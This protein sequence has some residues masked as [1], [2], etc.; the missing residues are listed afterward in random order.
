[1]ISNTITVIRTLFVIPLFLILALG[2]GEHRWLALW[3]FLGAGA[4]DIVDGKVARALGD[5]SSF[6][7][8]LDLLGDRLLTFAALAGLMAAGAWRGGGVMAA[9]AVS[10]AGLLVARCFVVASLKEPLGGRLALRVDWAESIKI[11][12]A[13]TGAGLLIA[14]PTL[15]VAWRFTQAQIGDGCLVAAAAMTVVIVTGYWL[16]A[17]PLFA[18][19]ERVEAQQMTAP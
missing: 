6:G 3:L 8:M 12:L 2:E 10:A 18:E 9:L 5:V 17:L 19:Q 13:F 4:L 7:A 14:P 16:R 11:A 15:L 1:M